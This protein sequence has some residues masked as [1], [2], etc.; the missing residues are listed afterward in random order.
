MVRKPMS[1]EKDIKT[2]K[3]TCQ[4]DSK[5]PPKKEETIK[6]SLLLAKK[7]KNQM[8]LAFHNI[9]QPSTLLD[10]IYQ[11]QD[12]VEQKWEHNTRFRSKNYINYLKTYIKTI[13]S[14]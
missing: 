7:T 1:K 6:T 5:W 11:Y 9:S 13:I 10:V 8:L 14:Y 4:I 3:Q 2:F 12:S